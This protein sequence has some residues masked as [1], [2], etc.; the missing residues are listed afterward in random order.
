MSEFVVMVPAGERFDITL[1]YAAAVIEQS[2][3]ITVRVKS[4]GAWHFEASPAQADNIRS[5]LQIWCQDAP[6]VIRWL[7]VQGSETLI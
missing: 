5:Q 4:P 6:A 7:T 3:G 1:A 2:K